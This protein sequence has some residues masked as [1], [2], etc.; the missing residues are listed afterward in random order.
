MIIR[1]IDHNGS[2]KKIFTI[3]QVIF[4]FDVLWVRSKEEG[5]ADEQQGNNEIIKRAVL[6]KTSVEH[7]QAVTLETFTKN[8]F[9]FHE[10]Q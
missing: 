6:R 4:Y 3:H 1:K 8:G 9:K 2:I 7:R 10:A 5:A